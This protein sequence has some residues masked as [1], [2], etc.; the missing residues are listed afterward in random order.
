MQNT[1]ETRA[2]LIAADFAPLTPAQRLAYASASETAIMRLCINGLGLDC[3]FIIDDSEQATDLD[4]VAI[5]NGS[6]QSTEWSHPNIR[7]AALL[8]N[9]IEA[10]ARCFEPWE[11]LLPFC[12]F[13]RFD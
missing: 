7:T 1:P 6:V 10:A 3:L 8:I 2:A 4:V 9:A 13:T 5:I 12:G 11:Q